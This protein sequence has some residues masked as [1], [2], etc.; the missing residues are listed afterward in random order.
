MYAAAAAAGWVI[1]FIPLSED[2]FL[3]PQLS[4]P[5]R[6]HQ[7]KV[8]DAREGDRARGRDYIPGVIRH[9]FQLVLWPLILLWTHR[10]SSASP[11]LCIINCYQMNAI[12][13]YMIFYR[14]CHLS[15]V[16]PSALSERIVVSGRNERQA[17]TKVILIH[18]YEN[19]FTKECNRISFSRAEQKTIYIYTYTRRFIHRARIYLLISVMDL[20]VCNICDTD[21][22]DVLYAFSVDWLRAVRVDCVRLGST[23]APEPHILGINIAITITLPGLLWINII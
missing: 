9:T 14:L 20:Y 5:P 4:T 6:P 7:L 11:S 22:P 10:T 21:W 16:V 17:T 2:Q 18:E 15:P 8:D 3:C 1:I 23:L 19:E 13:A 12:N